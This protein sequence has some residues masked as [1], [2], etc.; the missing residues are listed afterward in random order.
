[1]LVHICCSVDSHYFLRRLR[2][3]FPNERLVGYFYDPNI[4]P[5]S[6][7]LMRFHDVKRSCGA[8]GIDLICGEYD[9]ESWLEGTKGLENEPEKGKRCVYCFEFRVGNS[10]RKALE[11]GETSVTTTLLMSPKKDFAQLEAALNRAVAGTNLTP[12]AI[13]YR[14]NGGTNEQFE[15]AKKDKLYHQNYCGCVFGLSK[16]RD[17]QG[18]PIAELMSD[19]CGRALPGS[20]DERLGLYERVRGC[21]ER[22]ERFHLSRKYFLNYRLLRALVKFNGR[23]VT[24]YFLQYSNFKRE[25]VKFSVSEAACVCDELREGVTLLNLAKFNELVGMKFA[26]VR[27]LCREPI[28]VEAELKL[29]RELCGEFSHNPIIVL[30]EIPV[31]RYEIY[32]KNVLYN[33]SREMLVVE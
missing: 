16:Q 26:S 31:G 18:L 5:Y 28:G 6:E 13:D 1:M 33:D 3:D 25:N 23:V 24:S 14:K 22:G 4:H 7:F 15:L 8:L 17:A 32:A 2:A 29:R 20:I 27:E 11:I 21:E 12:V 10:A 19:V 30:D 9:Y